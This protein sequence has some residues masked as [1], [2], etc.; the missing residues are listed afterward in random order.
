MASTPA[1]AGRIMFTLAEGG[2]GMVGGFT[3]TVR[4]RL[5]DLRSS[6]HLP[7]LVQCLLG[8]GQPALCLGELFS[9]I[10]HGLDCT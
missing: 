9:R 6:Q 10:G 8:L 4:G 2:M 7:H 1:T 3:G 5:S